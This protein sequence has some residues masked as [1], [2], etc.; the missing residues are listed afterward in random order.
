MH[1]VCVDV[2]SVRD[3]RTGRDYLKVQ[4]H[5]GFQLLDCLTGLHLFL[6]PLCALR[7]DSSRAWRQ[8]ASRPIEAA[9]FK[10]YHDHPVRPDDEVRGVPGGLC[11][12]HS[13]VAEVAGQVCCHH[14][15]CLVLCA[16]QFGST[17]DVPTPPGE[18]MLL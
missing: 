7:S 8:E 16:Q 5:P 9:S 11:H 6:Q 14:V 17:S 3:G 15:V 13:V 10:H 2:L 18:T 4:R 1:G 12:L